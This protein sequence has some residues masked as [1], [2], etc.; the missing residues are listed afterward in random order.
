MFN[1]Y[2]IFITLVA[3]EAHRKEDPDDPLLRIDLFSVSDFASPANLSDSIPFM[4]LLKVSFC[5]FK[6]QSPP[7]PGSVQICQKS[8]TSH[9]VT[10]STFRFMTD[11][12]SGLLCYT[13]LMRSEPFFFFSAALG[14]SL[15]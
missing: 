9:F 6:I 4:I 1:F 2:L 15:Q 11:R 12:Q 3:S 8:R 10:L 13:L 5:L 7:P 14:D